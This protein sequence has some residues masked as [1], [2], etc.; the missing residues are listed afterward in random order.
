MVQITTEFCRLQDINIILVAQYEYIMLNVV[1][2]KRQVSSTG[3]HNF[4]P[5][6]SKNT[7]KQ[8]AHRYPIPSVISMHLSG[9]SL[10]L[11][12]APRSPILI[13]D[14]RALINAPVQPTGPVLS[15]TFLRRLLPIPAPVNQEIV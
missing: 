4:R 1:K 14:S 12:L 11:F 13:Y 2:V 5:S 3:I 6:S 7:N 15:R 10:L 8:A 9:V